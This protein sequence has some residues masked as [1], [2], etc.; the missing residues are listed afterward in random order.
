MSKNKEKKYL[1]THHTNNNTQQMCIGLWKLCNIWIYL[2]VK[3]NTKHNHYPRYYAKNYASVKTEEKKNT[4][5]H[6][7]EHKATFTTI[8][9]KHVSQKFVFGNATK[10]NDDDDDD[11]E[12]EN[13]M[14]KVW[15]LLN[16]ASHLLIAT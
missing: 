7:K 9:R 16:V 13:T 3:V 4:D 12:N 2:N 10:D 5:D 11:D 14:M 1:T 15:H 8:H 6:S